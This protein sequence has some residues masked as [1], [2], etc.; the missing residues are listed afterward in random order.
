MEQ[1]INESFLIT[2][3]DTI[4]NVSTLETIT[5]L[6]TNA[7]YLIL[8]ASHCSETQ[9]ADCSPGR[10]VLVVSQA[11][12]SPLCSAFLLE[13]Q[14]PGRPRAVLLPSPE[15]RFGA[16]LLSFCPFELPV[17]C[18]RGAHWSAKGFGLLLR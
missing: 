14:Q 2:F 3:P 17:H 13:G 18:K 11:G 5:L 4:T 8:A 7:R 12:G 9:R 6:K 15:E 16:D 10:D 1:V